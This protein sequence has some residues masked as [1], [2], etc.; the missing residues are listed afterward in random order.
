[1]RCK[2]LF[3]FL[4]L[5]IAFVSC[6]KDDDSSA[7]IHDPIAQAVLDDDEL[8]SYLETHY[9]IPAEAGQAFGR[10]DTIMNGETPLMGQVA[11]EDVVVND[12]NYKLYYLMIEE[13]V[14]DNPT[15]YDSIHVK[16]RG[17]T[18]DSV[19]FD[20]NKSFSSSSSWFNLAGSLIQ[21]WK[22]GFPHF[23]GG[24][25]ISMPGEPI[26]YENTGKGIIFFPSGLGYANFGSGLILPNEPLI[27]LIEL[28]DMVIADDDLDTVANRYEDADGDG[29]LA[30]D[31]TDGDGNPNYL[32]EDDD[33][34][35]FLT[36]DEDP[37]GDGDPTND[38]TNNNGIPNYLDP[39]DTNN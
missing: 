27:F 35:G 22:Y 10:I 4:T 25:N 39:L 14:G 12:I 11:T 23:K 19:K 29:E 2:T 26:A 34:D 30:N 17:F 18:L 7:E 31:D 33:G 24:T 15:R 21:G 13:G 9:Y 5:S 32:D 1:M 38:D 37:N 8:V 3:A 20:E 16:Y 6:N 36:R 28:G